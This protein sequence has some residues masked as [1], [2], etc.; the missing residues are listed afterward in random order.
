MFIDSGCHSGMLSKSKCQVLRAASVLHV[1]FVDPSILLSV[2][3]T[4]SS[5]AIVAIQ[6][7]VDTYC[8]H[9]AFI[10]GRG[11]VEEEIKHLV[12]GSFLVI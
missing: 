2:S 12:S 5:N 1:L 9:A 3:S 11:V 7:F 10:A 8:Q 4:I 6:N